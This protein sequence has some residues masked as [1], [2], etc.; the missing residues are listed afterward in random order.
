[1]ARARA[2]GA[3]PLLAIAGAGRGREPNPIEG[4][5]TSTGAGLTAAIRGAH[6]AARASAQ[7]QWL[8]SDL[9]G[10]RYKAFEWGLAWPRLGDC[11]DGALVHWHPADCIGNVGAAA[12]AV[13]LACISAAFS[14]GY[15]PAARALVTAA[16][17]GGQRAAMI[18]G[19]AA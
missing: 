6:A 12:A 5:K 7:V 19:R 3:S 8:V 11:M 10:E 17:D 2:R 9:D 4:A 1:R 14:R 15:A 18:V 13:H 16:N